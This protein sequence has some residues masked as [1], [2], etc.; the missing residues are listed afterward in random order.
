MTSYT[1][2]VSEASTSL[3]L[4]AEDEHATVTV[5]LNGT[6]VAASQGAYA[7]TWTEGANTL[8]VTVVNGEWSKT[9][10][11]AVTYTAGDGLLTFDSMTLTKKTAEGETVDADE[12]PAFSPYTRE[13]SIALDSVPSMVGDT[14]SMNISFPLPD[15]FTSD[16]TL[17]VVPLSGAIS[18]NEPFSVENLQSIFMQIDEGTLTPIDP[19][20]N[21]PEI[22][23]YAPG[24]GTT[25][26]LLIIALHFSGTQEEPVTEHGY[27]AFEVT[28]GEAT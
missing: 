15:W 25:T 22:Y 5:M 21:D 18:D 20:G 7:L 27:Y 16:D 17:V 12:T 11:V 24:P 9:Y 3:T 19:I 2:S 14:G 13:Y 28:V 26:T 6:A 4:T 8:A 10:T 23:A 1:A